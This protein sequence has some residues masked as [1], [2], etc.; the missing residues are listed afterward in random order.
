[1]IR[2]D[3]RIYRAEPQEEHI[4]THSFKMLGVAFADCVVGT[5]PEFRSRPDDPEA[6]LMVY[7]L[8]AAGLLALCISAFMPRTLPGASLRVCSNCKASV[9]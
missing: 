1:M 5:L 9:K 3:G 4:R 7:S 8:I 2:Y 6:N